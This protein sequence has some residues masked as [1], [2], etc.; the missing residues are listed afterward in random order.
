MSQHKWETSMGYAVSEREHLLNGKAS[1]DVGSEQD[2]GER[3]GMPAIVSGRAIANSREE[4]LALQ[5]IWTTDTEQSRQH[6]DERAAMW[7]QEVAPTVRRQGLASKGKSNDDGL[8]QQGMPG[9]LL[10]HTHLDTPNLPPQMRSGGRGGKAYKL[11]TFKEIMGSEET[12]GPALR[13][14]RPAERLPSHSPPPPLLQVGIPLRGRERTLLFSYWPHKWSKDS[15]GKNCMYWYVDEGAHYEGK[16]LKLRILN[17]F[18]GNARCI[19]F[20]SFP[21]DAMIVQSS[22]S[23]DPTTR[24]PR[25]RALNVEDSEDFSLPSDDGIIE[26]LEWYGGVIDQ[27]R[28]FV[29]WATLPF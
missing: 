10:S 17:G 16:A 6:A 24:A 1:A 22:V 4:T 7:I 9:A 27:G 25:H 8:T 13:A 23:E 3:M 26:N 12:P 15:R 14:S 5:G 28:L 11:F 20:L 18:I 2:N 29:H 19:L 21:A